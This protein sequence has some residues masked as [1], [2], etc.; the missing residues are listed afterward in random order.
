M[1]AV[2]PGIVVHNRV[3]Y[4]CEVCLGTC[5]REPKAMLV[6]VSTF[7]LLKKLANS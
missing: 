5:W 7:K 6:Y 3:K 2:G 1:R 4:E